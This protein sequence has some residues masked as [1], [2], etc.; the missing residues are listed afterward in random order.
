MNKLL[1]LLALILVSC[2]AQKVTPYETVSFAGNCPAGGT[3]NVKIFKGKTLNVKS[4][5]W[6]KAYYTM[7]DQA[8]KNVIQFNYNKTVKGNVQDA[9]YREEIVFELD[10]SI[11]NLTLADQ[12]LDDV[13]MLF[14]RFC[15]CKGQTGYYKVSKGHLVIAAAKHEKTVTLDFKSEEVPQIISGILISLK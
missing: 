15:F 7:D 2:N 11:G 5:E 1:L 3:C 13:K 4:D 12:S 10:K 14:G 6:G 9:G 8:D